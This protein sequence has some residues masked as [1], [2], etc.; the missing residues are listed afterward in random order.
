VIQHNVALTK[1]DS[2][3]MTA[4]NDN[5]YLGA[6]TVNGGVLE[7]QGKL[8][9]TSAANIN[10][11]ATLLLN[12]SV[13][14]IVNTLANANIAGGTLKV[15]DSQSGVTNTFAALTLSGTSVLD[16]GSGNSNNLA[17]NNLAGLSG[18]VQIWNWTGT[19]YT[20]GDLMDP[21]TD[22]MQD[23]FLFNT[24]PG[25]GNGNVIPG[26]QFFSDSG[27]TFA[28]SGMQVAYGNQFEFVAAVPEPATTAL[29][30]SVALCALLGYRRRI[31]KGPKRVAVK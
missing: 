22:F 19:P 11:G 21:G 28:G 9:G 10:T 16:F 6:T 2:A 7:V 23:R 25:F 17:F 1:V 12:S 27:S 24:D 5:T 31:V 30:G 4:T 14:N 18:P 3:R 26:L 8:S 15:D 13:N 20:F 29:I